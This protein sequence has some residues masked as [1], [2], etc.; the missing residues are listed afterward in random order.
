[1]ER[2]GVTAAELD[3]IVLAH[4]DAPTGCCRPPPATS[5]PLLG[6]D[7]AAAF[8]IAAACPGF[9][10]ALTVAEG[11]IAS[12]QSRDGAGGRRREA[13]RHHRL[14]RIAPPRSCSGTAPVPRWCGR[15]AGRARHPLDLPQV[16][17]RLAPLLY[18]PGGRR[19]GP[20]QREGGLRAVALH[21]DGRPRSVQA[22]R[23]DDGGGVRRRAR[24]APASPRS[25]SICSFRTRPTSASSRRRRSTPAFPWTR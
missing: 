15:R 24:A 1:M 23:A 14:G 7:N 19:R 25:T 21:E 3:T 22:R 12:G 20:D 6:A 11:L 2:A 17:G 4:R 18:R 5:R 8:D 16:D 9:V 13:H 10:Y